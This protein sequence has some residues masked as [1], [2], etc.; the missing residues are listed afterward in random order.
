MQP[1]LS[2]LPQ[3][4]KFTLGTMNLGWTFD[5]TT[6]FVKVVRAAMERNIPLHTS[7]VYNNGQT[8]NIIKLAF[9]EAPTQ[10]PLFIAK[11]YCYNATQIR[12][13]VEEVVERLGVEQIPIAQLAK[14]DHR[15]R[16]IVDDVL[17][18]GAMYQQ[19]CQL[20]EEGKVGHWTF[21]SFQKF[22]MDANS[23]VDNDLFGSISFYFN[24]LERETDTTSWEKISRK[25]LP[26]IA[27]RGLSGGLVEPIN[28]KSA[29][30]PGKP[31][32]MIDRRKQLEPLFEQSG[33]SSWSEFS[34]RFLVSHPQVK[35]I[36]IGTGSAKRVI[37]NHEFIS[38]THCLNPE[39]VSQIHHHLSNWADQRTFDPD[40]PYV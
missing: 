8:L 3:C 9:K 17:S 35:T 25:Q 5:R 7:H 1:Y 16:E 29:G 38:N 12:L 18:Q 13:D 19:L 4:G 21:E 30:K 10:I 24:A 32:E 6:E 20:R 14:N 27:L 36:V 2:P 15:H 22:A 23:A 34:I 26:I 11:I 37:E 31:L 28:E 39:V 40:S 33:C